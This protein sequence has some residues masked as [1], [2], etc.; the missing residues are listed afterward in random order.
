MAAER[1][2]ADHRA[3]HV[4]VDIDVADLEALDRFLHRI[5]DPGMDAERQPVAR[6]LDRSQHLVEPIG[7]VAHNMQHWA[8][9]F[10]RQ[11]AGIG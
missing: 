2:H 5:V 10:V 6:A 4:A 3:D 7:A 1:L 8:E 9:H 11:L